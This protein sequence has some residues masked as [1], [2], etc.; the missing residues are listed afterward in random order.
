MEA[1]KNVVRVESIWNSNCIETLVEGEVRLPAEARALAV[2]ARLI[3]GQAETLAGRVDLDGTVVFHVLY[4]GEDGPGVAEQSLAFD[5]SIKIDNVTPAMKAQ[6]FGQAKQIAWQQSGDIVTISAVAMLYARVSGARDVPVVQGFSGAPV[7]TLPMTL[8][9]MITVDESS[10]HILVRGGGSMPIRLPLAERVL[11]AR[12]NVGQPSAVAAMGQVQ[13]SADV[14]VDV[15]YQSVEADEPL[16]MHTFTIPLNE[17]LSVP[18]AMMG[19]PADVQAQVQSA[20]A[21]VVSED[22]G[23]SRQI[24]CEVMVRLNC[25]AQ[26]VI[27][28]QA[29]SDAYLPGSGMKLSHS[30]VNVRKAAGSQT[31]QQSLREAI[32]IGDGH[33][34]MSRALWLQVSP[35]ITDLSGDTA[36]DVS[37]VADCTLVY[38]SDEGTITSLRQELPFTVSTGIPASPAPARILINADQAEANMRSSTEAELCFTLQLTLEEDCAATVQWVSD[39]E[40]CESETPLMRGIILYFVQ[41]GDTLWDIARRYGLAPDEVAALNPAIGDDVAPGQKLVLYRM[42]KA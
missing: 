22:G 21:S 1:I 34:P 42:V 6:G 23:P 13:V 29:I 4:A 14:Q 19:M 12:A 31:A 39:A 8:E 41:P 16:A 5:H 24:D 9:G 2:A 36:L 26:Q 33:Q 40:P 27:E 7:Q 18:G 30:K 37:G 35:Y 28:A 25:Q 11:L 32:E 20:Q 3:P 17:T 38:L 10:A 15:L